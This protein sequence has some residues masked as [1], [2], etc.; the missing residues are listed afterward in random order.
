MNLNIY[1]SDIVSVPSPCPVALPTSAHD[2]SLAADLLESDDDDSEGE[3]IVAR[4]EAA[5]AAAAAS[6]GLSRT[7]CQFTSVTSHNFSTL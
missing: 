6:R 7:P 2:D 3:D 4:A 5:A 1:I